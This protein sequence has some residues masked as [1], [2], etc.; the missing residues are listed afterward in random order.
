[1][2]VAGAAR[3]FA[4]NFKFAKTVLSLIFVQLSHMRTELSQTAANAEIE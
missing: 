1:L 4:S 2:N 3:M